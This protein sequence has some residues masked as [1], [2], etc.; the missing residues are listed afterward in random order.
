MAHHTL[1]TI[2]VILALTHASLAFS[3]RGLDKRACSDSMACLVRVPMLVDLIEKD[4]AGAL[5]PLTYEPVLDFL[6]GQRENITGCLTDVHCEE[7][8]HKYTGGAV[9][10]LL[11]YACNSGRA[12]LLEERACISRDDFEEGILQCAGILRIESD[13]T[14]TQKL[15]WLGDNSCQTIDNMYKCVETSTEHVCSGRAARLMGQIYR[16]IMREVAQDAEC[17]QDHF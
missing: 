9:L 8:E 1:T 15:A 16:T 6:C 14:L 3:F 10:E 5:L 11:D 4:F 7:T 17:E 2:L 12:D 13:L